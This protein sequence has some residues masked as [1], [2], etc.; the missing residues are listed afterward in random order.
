MNK[1]FAAFAML[2]FLIAMAAPA[3]ADVYG[4][5]LNVVLTNQTPYPVEPGSNV[6][7]GIQLQ[8]NGKDNAQNVYLEI[9]SE[10]PFELLPGQEVLKFFSQ[11]PSLDSVKTSYKLR[12]NGSAVTN[13]YYL[14]FNIYLGDLQSSFFTKAVNINVQGIPDL[15]VE[16]LSTAPSPVEPG[17]VIEVGAVLKNVGTGS[18]RNVQL[19]FNSTIDEI[20]PV[21]AKGSVFVGD[22]APGAEKSAVFDVSIDSSAEEKTY[23]IPLIAGYK[24]E[25]NNAVTETFS[26]G[27]PVRG[28][29]MLDIVKIEPLYDRDALRVEIANKGTTSAKSIEASLRIDGNTM[30]VDYVSELK[31]T[32]KTTMDFSPL[33]ATGGMAQL[34]MN[35]VGPGL[36]KGQVTKEVS[37]N[38]AGA[39]SGDG[40]GTAII[41]VIIIAVVGYYFWRRRKKKRKHGQ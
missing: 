38:F 18:A 32:K 21:L 33:P 40:T 4:S 37:L 29:V 19:Q 20:K 10:S 6:D 16:S 36:E 34:V 30:D 7:I 26:V 24:D 31:A 35:Y 5:N 39:S 28:S 17:S 13:N 14:N 41:I 9:A 23:T 11:V 8:N 3:H 15:V 22:I 2:A 25:N 1:A 12:V 27:L